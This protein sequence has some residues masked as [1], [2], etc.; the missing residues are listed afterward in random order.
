MAA[1]ERSTPTFNPVNVIFETA[2]LPR[3]SLEADI[4][5]HLLEGLLA[6]PHGFRRGAVARPRDGPATRR[7]PGVPPRTGCE[8]AGFA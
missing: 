3:R 7:R 8:A 4:P 5:E 6:I 1:L 2:V